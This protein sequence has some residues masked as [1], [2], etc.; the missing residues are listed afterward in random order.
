MVYFFFFVTRSLTN[1]NA[2]IFLL[3]FLLFVCTFPLD[4]IAPVVCYCFT[5]RNEINYYLCIPYLY[6]FFFVVFVVGD[7]SLHTV[8]EQYDDITV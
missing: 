3:L 1:S 7:D 6:L 5:L 4:E 8:W 2:T